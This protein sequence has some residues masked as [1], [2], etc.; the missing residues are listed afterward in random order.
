MAKPKPWE[1]QPDEGDKAF[2]AFRVYRDM[3]REE[4]SVRAVAR[5]VNKSS[6]QIGRWSSRHSWQKRIAAWNAEQDRRE[7]EAAEA[8]RIKDVLAMRKRHANLAV[9]MLEKAANALAQIPEDEIKATDISRMVDVASKLERISRGVVGEVVEE[10]QGEPATPAVQFYMP[11]N[12]RDQKAEEE[13][14][15]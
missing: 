15:D 10:R 12:N 4:R 1:Q 2:D 3:S 7:R 6:T 8:Q 5:A 13:E 14:E 11:S 9:D